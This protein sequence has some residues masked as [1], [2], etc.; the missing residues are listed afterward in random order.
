MND[1][2]VRNVP[3]LLR[4]GVAGVCP[5][6]GVGKLFSGFLTIAPACSHCRQSFEFAD[7]GDGPA[8]F[9]IMIVGFIVVAGVLA[10]EVLY[11][12]PY[13]V[14]GVVW[15]PVTALLCL[16]LLRPFKAI[17]VTLQY[18][19]RAVEARFGNDRPD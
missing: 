1:R 8:V 17:L 4:S 16:A 2:V 3:S 18:R 10:M 13:W 6:C 15:L 5:H 12:P 19:N 9:I 14:H 7:S 11:Q